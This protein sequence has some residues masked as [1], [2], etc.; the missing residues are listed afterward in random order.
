MHT[1][2]DLSLNLFFVLVSDSIKLLL[3]NPILFL[4]KLIIAFLYGLGAFYAVDL[5]KSLFSL[6]SLTYEQMVGFDFNYFFTALILLLGLT[7]F[8][9]FVDLLFSGFYPII[10]SLSEKKKL[11]FK[12]A[13]KL[14]KPKIVRILLIGVILWAIVTVISLIEATIILYFNLSN[15]GFILSFVITFVFIFVFYFIY[16]K[17]IFENLNLSKTFSQSL[18]NSLSNKK[19]VFALS[20]IPFLVSIMKFVLAYFSDSII[21]ILIFWVLV[22]LTGL[23]YSV[24]VVVNQLAYEKLLNNKK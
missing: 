24:H 6:Q 18:F 13:L 12:E 17:T 3:K 16:P 7:I 11:S 8:T 4:P 22:V 21:S 9:F 1:K 15:T 14:F 10:I 23:I 19:L 5:S 20:L 2:K